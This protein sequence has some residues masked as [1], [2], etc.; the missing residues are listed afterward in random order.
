MGRNHIRVDVFHEK[1]SRGLQAALNWLSIV[2]LAVFGAFI[3]WIA[4]KVISDTLQYGSTAQTPWATPLIFRKASGTQGSSCCV[5]YRLRRACRCCCARR[6][7][8]STATSAE[9]HQAGVKE[10][11]DDWQRSGPSTR[12]AAIGGQQRRVRLHD[13]MMLVGLPTPSDGGSR[14]LGGVAAFGCRSST[15]SRRRLGR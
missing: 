8:G 5:G 7:D 6:I 3:A 1:F 2:A 14:H 9:E 4:F 12:Q 15:R 11:L 10:E 13:G